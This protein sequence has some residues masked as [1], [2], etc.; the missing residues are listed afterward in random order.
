MSK[1]DLL[2]SE[3]SCNLFWQKFK[4][5]LSCCPSVCENIKKNHAYQPNCFGQKNG[6]S[7]LKFKQVILLHIL[8]R[9]RKNPNLH[10][11]LGKNDLLGSELSCNFFWQKFKQN[12]SSCPS[13]CENIKKIHAYQPNC[14][15]QK[16]GVSPLK[17]K[18]VILLHI[19][20]RWRKNP[21]LHLFFQ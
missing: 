1:N 14:F 2:G 4:Q 6:V 8:R 17:I 20:R 7:P 19:L 13:V 15:G 9:W 16:N 10:L 5:N 3:L 21:N 18:Q 12:L 11:F